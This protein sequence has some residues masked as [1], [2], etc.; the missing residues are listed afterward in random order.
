LD[1]VEETVTAGDF[2]KTFSD[3]RRSANKDARNAAK[4]YAWRGAERCLNNWLAVH[5]EEDAPKVR[6]LLRQ[7]S[8]AQAPSPHRNTYPGCRQSQTDSPRPEKPEAARAY[9]PAGAS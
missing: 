6:E 7:H 4:S 5:P 8:R 3:R 1:L 9:F 2:Y